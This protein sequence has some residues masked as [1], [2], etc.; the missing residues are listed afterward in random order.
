MSTRANIILQDGSDK[1]Y[2]YRH[3]DGYPSCTLKSLQKFTSWI[4]DGKIRNNLYQG[5]GWLIL[6]GAMEYDV[7]LPKG[8]DIKNWKV[9]AYE[10]TTEI[11]GDIEYLYTIDMQTG[12][13]KVQSASYN[14]ETMRQTF[15]TL[16]TTELESELANS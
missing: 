7:Q 13:I 8:D 16:S 6:L 3:S 14:W 15:K 5:A 10:P 9:G 12:N 2:F 1:L 11:H 4:K